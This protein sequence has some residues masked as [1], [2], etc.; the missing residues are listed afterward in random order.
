[1]QNYREELAGLSE[2]VP[3]NYEARVAVTQPR[4]LNMLNFRLA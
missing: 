1:M 4:R 3:Q 2:C